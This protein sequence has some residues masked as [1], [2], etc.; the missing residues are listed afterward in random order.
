MPRQHR[1]KAGQNMIIN[2]AELLARVGGDHEFLAEVVQLFLNDCP[3]QLAELSEA[4]SKQDAVKIQRLAHAVKGQVSNLASET[5]TV[6][7]MRLEL[8]G[9]EGNIPGAREQLSL[10]E[11]SIEQLKIALTEICSQR[12]N[13]GL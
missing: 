1:L 13:L 3:K 11:G 9:K 10:L 5:A 8:M 7:A 6:A 4:V 2:R 12:D